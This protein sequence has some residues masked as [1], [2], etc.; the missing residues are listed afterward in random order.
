MIHFKYG[1]EKVYGE[2]GHELQKEI[3]KIKCSKILHIVPAIPDCTTT[4]ICREVYYEI[5]WHS[6]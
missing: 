3:N 6:H 2:N 1:S 5:E 4:D